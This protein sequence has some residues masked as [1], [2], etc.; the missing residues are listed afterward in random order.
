MNCVKCGLKPATVS[1]VL[2]GQYYRFLCEDCR[3]QP[4]VNSG[5][6][7]WERDLDAQDHEA[8]IQQPYNKDGSINARFA[9]LYPK[10]AKVLFN[11]DQIRR[12]ELGLSQEN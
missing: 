8:D 3:P 2:E 1:A 6:A 9:K 12:A 4:K 10:Q 11:D 5:H 7:R